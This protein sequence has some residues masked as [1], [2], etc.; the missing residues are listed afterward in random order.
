MR[1]ITPRTYIAEA[2]GSPCVVP[3]YESIFWP[4]M[5]KKELFRYVFVRTIA[6]DGQS[7]HMFKRAVC[8]LSELNV[9]VALTNRAPSE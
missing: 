6:S 2:S 9:F 1:G 5:K 7:E 4:W 3:S 8:Q